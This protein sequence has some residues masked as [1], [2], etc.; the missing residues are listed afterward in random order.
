MVNFHPS[1]VYPVRVEID[2]AEFPRERAEIFV[3][4]SVPDRVQRLSSSNSTVGYVWPSQHLSLQ[5]LVEIFA[6]LVHLV[7]HSL[8]VQKTHHG[9]FEPS[10]IP[11]NN[12]DPARIASDTSRIFLTRYILVQLT[13]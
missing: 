1:R 9:V 10:E 3:T 5:S 11:E 7:H 2:A 8:F 6:P 12:Y 13:E 4:S